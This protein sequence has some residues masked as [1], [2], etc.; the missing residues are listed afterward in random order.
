MQIIKSCD[1]E[2]L[3]VNLYC[4]LSFDTHI[5][6]VVSKENQIVCIIRRTFNSLYIENDIKIVQSLCAPTFKIC[7]CD[8]KSTLKEQFILVE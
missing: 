3:E 5:Q 7:Q 1:E 8:L 2:D 4:E 6:E